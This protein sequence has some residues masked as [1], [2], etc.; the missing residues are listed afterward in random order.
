MTVTIDVLST[1]LLSRIVRQRSQAQINALR[2]AAD[3]PRHAAEEA[4]SMRALAG[5]FEA[6]QDLVDAFREKSMNA[7]R[8]D[9]ER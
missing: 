5:I 3:D 8:A 9:Q 1:D 7:S 2:A 6:E 4:G